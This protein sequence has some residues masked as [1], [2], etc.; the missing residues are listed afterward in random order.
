MLQTTAQGG[1]GRSGTSGLKQGL[2]GGNQQKGPCFL[3]DGDTGTGGCGGMGIPKR[4][5]ET[6]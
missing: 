1:Q 5:A 2:A 4:D 3:G 6:C